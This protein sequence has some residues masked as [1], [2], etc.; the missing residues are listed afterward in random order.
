VKKY[1]FVATLRLDPRNKI[2][3]FFSPTV[4][5]KFLYW[6]GGAGGVKGGGGDA[7]LTSL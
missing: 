1:I 5:A 3:S 2:T 4:F 7:S 6:E